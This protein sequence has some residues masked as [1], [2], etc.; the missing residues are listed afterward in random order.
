M[1]EITAVTDMNEPFWAA[2]RKVK[3]LVEKALRQADEYSLGDVLHYANTGQWQLWHGDNSV[4]FT[5]IAR[6]PEHQ[7]CVLIL[8]AGELE[9]IVDLEPHICAWAKKEGCKY[10]EIFGRRGWQRA[11]G[12]YDEQYAV[13]RK[14]L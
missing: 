14:E 2:W 8:A 6:Y 10:M 9:E 1:T 5:R 4:G 13:L 7:T 11:L 3:P 12:G